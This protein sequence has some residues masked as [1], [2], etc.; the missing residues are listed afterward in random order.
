M[1]TNLT[2]THEDAGSI[3]GLA[4]W[5]KDLV[6]LWLWCSSQTQLGTGLWYWPA[7]AA[8]IRPLTWELPYAA[9][10]ALKKEKEKEKKKIPANLSVMINAHSSNETFPC[11]RCG[12]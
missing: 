6:L 9:H 7:A 3:P 12:H 11:N 10:A 1:A 4:Q 2:S 8:L 5:V